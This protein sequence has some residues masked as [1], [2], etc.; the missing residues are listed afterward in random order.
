MK[1]VSLVN[2]LGVQELSSDIQSLAKKYTILYTFHFFIF[3]LTQTFMIVYI[4]DKVGIAQAAVLSTFLLLFQGVLDYPLGVL[5]DSIGQK[6]VLFFSYISFSVGFISV[7]FANNFIEFIPAF[8]IVGLA[9]ALFS[10]A[11]ETYIDNNYSILINEH[12]ADRKIYGFFKS[13]SLTL[14]QI[15]SLLSF[16]IGGLLSTKF[17]R[18]AIFIFQ[19][20]IGFLFAFVILIYL[21]DFKNQNSERKIE[22]K[23][24]KNFLN[25]SKT[26]LKFFFKSKKNFF[27]LTAQIFFQSIWMIWAILILLVIY[28]GYTGDDFLAGSFRS[29]VYILTIPILIIVGNISKKI[30]SNNILSNLHFIHSALFFGGFALIIFVIPME[31]SLNLIGIILITLNFTISGIFNQLIEIIYQKEVLDLVPIK[32]RNSI[33]SLIPTIVGIFSIPFMILVGNLIER[34]NFS[35]GI[36]ILAILEMIAAIFFYLYFKNRPQFDIDSVYE[37]ESDREVG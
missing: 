27:F 28:F 25:I 6:W 21:N 34:Y 37:K 36:L 4:I 9:F 31:N 33:Y 22:Q 30:T 32:I 35:I 26:G 18:S 10:G 19:G 8:V 20:V 15:T 3:L 13:R 11:Y 14:V 17:G 7:A 5:S 12:D 1:S 29:I 16:L 23:S 24:I 2:F